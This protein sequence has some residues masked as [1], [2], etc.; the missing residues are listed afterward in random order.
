M[1]GMTRCHF[2]TSSSVGT[3]PVFLSG[4]GASS[5][6]RIAYSVPAG[7]LTFFRNR[8]MLP[9][10]LPIRPGELNRYRSAGDSSLAFPVRSAVQ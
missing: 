8:R 3:R 1:I 2:A 4:C 5:V 7:S 6:A 10:G 9:I